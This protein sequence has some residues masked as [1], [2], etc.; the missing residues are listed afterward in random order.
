MRCFV[1]NES[2][3]W[4]VHSVSPLELTDSSKSERL[5]GLPLYL[6][7]EQWQGKRLTV[8]RFLPLPT[9]SKYIK[10]AL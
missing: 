9:E 1:A 6:L 4:R 10:E 5:I 2:N 7:S 8:L 3:F